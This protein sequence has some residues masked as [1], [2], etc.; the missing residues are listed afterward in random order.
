MTLLIQVRQWELTYIHTCRSYFARYIA[1][2][3]MAR[4]LADLPADFGLLGEQSSRFPALDANEPS[5]KI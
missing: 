5:C 4:M 1:T 2:V 3:C